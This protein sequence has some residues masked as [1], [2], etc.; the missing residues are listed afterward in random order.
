MEENETLEE[1]FQREVLEETDIRIN[2]NNLFP[3]FVIKY[4][5]KNHEHIGENKFRLSWRFIKRKYT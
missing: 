5:N 2:T 1:C 3:F 4:Y